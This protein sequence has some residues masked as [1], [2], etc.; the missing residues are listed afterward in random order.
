MAV[1][2]REGNLQYMIQLVFGLCVT[3]WM[4]TL[5]T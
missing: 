2:E 5:G 4:I 1:Y 3:I